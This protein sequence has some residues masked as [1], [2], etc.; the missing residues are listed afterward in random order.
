MKDI[1]AVNVTRHR[2]QHSHKSANKSDYMPIEEDDEI[3]GILTSQ[4]LGEV[5]ANDDDILDGI[6]DTGASCDASSFYLREGKKA[7]IAPMKR[8]FDQ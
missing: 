1:S 2:R 3:I 8:N 6:D 7:S 5:I 4:V